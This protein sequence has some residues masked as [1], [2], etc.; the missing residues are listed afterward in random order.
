MRLIN[1]H[2]QIM[3]PEF[4]LELLVDLIFPHISIFFTFI[5]LSGLFWQN[6]NGIMMTY[7]NGFKSII[8]WIRNGKLRSAVLRL[9]IIINLYS[10]NFYYFSH[11][12]L[13]HKTHMELPCLSSKY[14]FWQPNAHHASK[15]NYNRMLI[16][17]VKFS[18]LLILFL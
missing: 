9:F 4:G 11:L 2:S 12:I 14:S 6:L 18:V 16:L 15:N 10:H 3:Q 17:F 13:S 5:L 8:C 7:L 1:A